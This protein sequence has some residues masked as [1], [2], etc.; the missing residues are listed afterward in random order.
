MGLQ[1]RAGLGLLSSKARVMG[2]GQRSL[3]VPNTHSGTFP[4]SPLKGV[5]CSHI[6]SL[7]GEARGPI[8]GQRWGWNPRMG[9]GTP[10]SGRSPHICRSGQ[11]GQ[12]PGPTAQLNRILALE[13]SARA[14][15]T[16][17][18][19]PPS[20]CPLPPQ[21]APPHTAQSPAQ[22]PLGPSRELF[23][24][25]CGLFTGA[26]GQQAGR[27]SHSCPGAD[28]SPLWAGESAASGSQRLSS[29][30][31][32]SSAGTATWAEVE[33]GASAWGR[34]ALPTLVVSLGG[35]KAQAVHMGV[36]EC[37]EWQWWDVMGPGAGVGR[38]GE[39]GGR[40]AFWGPTMCGA[41]CWGLGGWRRSGRAVLRAGLA[42]VVVGLGLLL[43]QP[44]LLSK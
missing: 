38:G 3:Q 17:A 28:K 21:H 44:L 2:G 40:R 35:G 27:M 8:W 9:R 23:A 42:V 4:Q 22:G 12:R 43:P 25:G 36:P 31:A 10:E 13:D 1:G 41:P 5:P 33:L 30:R 14:W 11:C 32:T 26:T 7:A 16:P 24:Q 34:G 15:A 39:P 29:N 20:V 37:V 19:P 6:H 18:H